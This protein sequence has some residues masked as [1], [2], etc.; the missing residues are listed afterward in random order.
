V[1]T[2]DKSTERNEINQEPGTSLKFC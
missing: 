2:P 1:I